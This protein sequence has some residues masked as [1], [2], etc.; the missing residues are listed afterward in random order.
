VIGHLAKAIS[1][2][3]VRIATSGFQTSG[4]YYTAVLNT[5]GTYGVVMQNDT[6]S[7]IKLTLADATH[8]FV[9]TLPA[10]SIAS[11]RWKK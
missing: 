3:A 2:G 9:Y 7:S 8:S 6:D 10:K 4:L 11:F 1:T 5:D